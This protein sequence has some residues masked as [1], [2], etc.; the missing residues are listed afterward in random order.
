SAGTRGRRAKGESAGDQWRNRTPD[1]SPCQYAGRPQPRGGPGCTGTSAAR[2]T[3]SGNSTG[4]RKPW[5]IQNDRSQR[6]QVNGVI[7]R[8]LGG[9]IVGCNATKKAC[10]SFRGNRNLPWVV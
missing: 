10:S 7:G 6:A 9:G 3:A 1:P 8:S 5:K 2:G 4:L